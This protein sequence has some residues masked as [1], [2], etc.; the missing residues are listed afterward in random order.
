MT[1]LQSFSLD[2]GTTY[3]TV[4]TLSGGAYHTWGGFNWDAA[5]NAWVLTSNQEWEIEPDG[6][7]Q[8]R[9]NHDH[10][11]HGGGSDTALGTYVTPDATTGIV[12]MTNPSLSNHGIVE[13]Y[14]K[15]VEYV[16][17][18][19]VSGNAPF[20]NFGNLHS[21]YTHMRYYKASSGGGYDYWQNWFFRSGIDTQ[22]IQPNGS[23][24][25]IKYNTSTST[26]EDDSTAGN[27]VTISVNGTTVELEDSSGTVI[28]TFTNPYS[29]SSG[30]GS[31][32]G[33]PNPLSNNSS[34]TSSKKVFH[35][36]W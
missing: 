23:Y 12:T 14:C 19:G 6:T 2:G 26:W 3:A 25:D 36:F 32:G 4:W 28:G 16:Q 20:S 34:S 11:S 21:A 18:T 22:Y 7:G 24:H 30:G 17:V 27:P 1:T 15:P 8:Y 5:H 33:G 13:V 9:F 31:S 10:A 35:N 29:S